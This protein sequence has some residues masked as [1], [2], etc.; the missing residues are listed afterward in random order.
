MLRDHHA[1]HAARLSGAEQGPEVLW[2]LQAV[3]DQQQ[4]WEPLPKQIVEMDIAE[5]RGFGQH[6]LVMS[7]A[8]HLIQPMPRHRQHGNVVA[9]SVRHQTIQAVNRVRNKESSHP[10]TSAQSLVDGVSAVQILS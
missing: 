4:R 7:I 1:M 10:A 6:T 5:G 2:V 9:P 3:Q 8:D